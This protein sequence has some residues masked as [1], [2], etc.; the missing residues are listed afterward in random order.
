MIAVVFPHGEIVV[1]V[2]RCH[3]QAPEL[4]R[5]EIGEVLGILFGSIAV[6]V[7]LVA[8]REHEA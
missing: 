1:A 7:H 8:K 4:L 2:D 5:R 6:I 3:R